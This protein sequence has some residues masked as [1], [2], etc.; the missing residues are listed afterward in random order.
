MC[1]GRRCCAATH[2]GGPR[3]VRQRAPP[4]LRQRQ[5]QNKKS[6]VERR[7]ERHAR[8]P[9]RVR[10]RRQRYAV[11]LTRGELRRV[12]D[13]HLEAEEGGGDVDVEVLQAVVRAPGAAPVQPEQREALL[14]RV[15][16]RVCVC[17]CVCSCECACVCACV[18]MRVYC[19]SPFVVNIY[20]YVKDTTKYISSGTQ[21]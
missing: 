17:R 18:C 20:I 8:H 4:V 1:A 16:V 7:L 2:H 9:V 13:G 6:K 19:Q 5:R 15:C 3:Q 21:Q 14:T 12:Q 10:E 11:P